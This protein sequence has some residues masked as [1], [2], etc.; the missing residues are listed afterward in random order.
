MSEEGNL[1]REVERL[2]RNSDRQ[3]SVGLDKLVCK[4]GVAAVKAWRNDH[5]GLIHKLVG[6]PRTL[7]HAVSR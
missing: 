2:L 6:M 1:W 4:Y 7:R 3:G 5:E